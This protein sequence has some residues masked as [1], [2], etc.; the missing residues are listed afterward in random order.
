[1]KLY[2]LNK[3]L[4][5]L[6]FLYFSS[7]Y[8]FCITSCERDDYIDENNT[9]LLVDSVNISS[10][11]RIYKPFLITDSIIHVFIPKGED[12]KSVSIELFYKYQEKDNNSETNCMLLNNCNLSDF[13]VPYN[14]LISN[15]GIQKQYTINVYDIPVLLINS[16][17]KKRIKSKTERVEGCKLSLVD[18]SGIYNYLGTAGVR[19]RGSSSWAQHKRPYNV[20]MDEKCKILG[21]KKSKHWIL[22]ANCYYDRTQLHNATALQI[23]R[24]TDFDWVPQCRFVEL[25]LNDEHVGLYL[26]C[27]KIKEGSNKIPIDDDGYLLES[28]IHDDVENSF[29]TSYFFKTGDK[30]ENN[31]FWELK[32]PEDNSL[33]KKIKKDLNDIEY[34]IY[35]EETF[36]SG[37]YRKYLDIESV[38]NWLLVENVTLNAESMRT[39]NMYIYK[40]NLNGKL[41]VGPPWDFD[42]STFGLTGVY[43]LY[44]WETTWCFSQLIKD[45]YFRSRIKQKWDKVKDAWENEIPLF[46]EEE[47]SRIFN[48]AIRNDKMWPD[49]LN[50]GYRE[51]YYM[52]SYLGCVEDMKNQYLAQLY[53]MDAYINQVI[54]ND[55]YW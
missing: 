47:L 22:L 40:S 25:I 9:F 19:S 23:A 33:I 32:Y 51:E 17:E 3:N 37:E 41:K 27:E 14:F 24:L 50:Y 26:I 13:L 46:I 20:K 10:H 29:Q 1:M 2:P 5:F 30:F 6:V 8:L 15:K 55:I 28:T 54:N 35:S 44:A 39:K 31:L 48:A 16:P 36:A 38:I 42:Y 7:I 18:E 11:S 52:G 45:K 34:L 43:K 49:L 53:W 4:I 21:M 12:L